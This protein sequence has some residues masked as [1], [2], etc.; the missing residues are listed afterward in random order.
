[1]ETAL[2]KGSAS[3]F[4]GP[5][6]LDH[7]GAYKREKVDFSGSVRQRI[8][9]EKKADTSIETKHGKEKVA[10]APLP[11]ASSSNY[12]RVSLRFFVITW[13]MIARWMAIAEKM[14]MAW[15]P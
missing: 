10:S 1:M 11:A 6:V 4:A 3:L 13:M 15:K 2:N 7:A 14:P 8:F 9:L 12:E 5:F